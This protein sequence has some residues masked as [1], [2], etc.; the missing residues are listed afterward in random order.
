[1]CSLL[2][3][4]NVMFGGTMRN[5]R[6]PPSHP[7]RLFL[8]AHLRQPVVILSRIIGLMCTGNNIMYG[9]ALP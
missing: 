4:S 1:M 7:A 8:Q 3:S 5:F 2:Y 6:I 9:L